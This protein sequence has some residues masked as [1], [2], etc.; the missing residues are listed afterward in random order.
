MAGAYFSAN[1]F[2]VFISLKYLF[3]APNFFKKVTN[4]VLGVGICCLSKLFSNKWYLLRIVTSNKLCVS[5][6]IY[7]NNKPFSLFHIRLL[8]RPDCYGLFESGFR[9]LIWDDVE[10]TGVTVAFSRSS[11]R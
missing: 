1:S 8:V 2:L 10:M 7:E 9:V 5:A 3:I 4:Y 11:F 6:Y